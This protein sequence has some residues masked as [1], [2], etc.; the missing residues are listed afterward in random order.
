V[1]Y[2]LIQYLAKLY[3]LNHNKN[4]LSCDYSFNST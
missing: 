3:I 1:N 4:S 2:E